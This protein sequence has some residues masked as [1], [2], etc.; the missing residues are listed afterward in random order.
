MREDSYDVVFLVLLAVLFISLGYVT[1]LNEQK[2]TESY[3]ASLIEDKNVG[4]ID[5][6]VIPGYGDYDGTLTKGDVVLM[7][8]IQDYYMPNP[9]KLHIE[10][11]G[12]LEI[13]ST[14]DVDKVSYGA[15]M[16]GYV[17]A[18]GGNRF[19]LKYDDGTNLAQSDDDCFFIGKAR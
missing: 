6:L 10:D 5:S 16:I 14:V 7:S 4:V 1:V 19:Y 8:Q 3:N 12:E 15:K 2:R 17:G 18:S 9:K 13:K 11:G